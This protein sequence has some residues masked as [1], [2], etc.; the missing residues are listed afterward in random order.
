MS[1]YLGKLVEVREG[2]RVLARYRYNH[3]GE[4]IEKIVAGEHTYYLYEHR[5][6]VA[7]LDGKGT[8]RR[9]Y[10]YLA[11][12]PVAVIDTP[13]I[14]TARETEVPALAQL[15]TS[16]TGVWRAWVGNVESSGLLGNQKCIYG[17]KCSFAVDQ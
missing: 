12:H 7:E 11:E 16:L 14:G 9:Q 6:L 10:V 17:W 15:I 13:H 1:P 8:I 4:R 3:R 5:K 2:Q